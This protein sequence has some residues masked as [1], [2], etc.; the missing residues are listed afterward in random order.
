MLHYFVNDTSSS[1]EFVSE[2]NLQGLSPEFF[3]YIY[4]VVIKCFY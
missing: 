4:V 2:T 3:H 1:N